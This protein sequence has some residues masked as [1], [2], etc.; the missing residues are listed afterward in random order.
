[1]SLQQSFLSKCKLNQTIYNQPLVGMLRG[2]RILLFIDPF[3][4]PSDH[5][6]R[7]EKKEQNEKNTHSTPPGFAWSSW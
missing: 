2:G 3:F 4:R 1:M 5:F 6:K 7:T